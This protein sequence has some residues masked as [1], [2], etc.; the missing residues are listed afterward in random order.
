MRL[1]SSSNQ[2]GGVRHHERPLLATDSAFR[3]SDQTRHGSTTCPRGELGWPVVADRD[4]GTVSRISLSHD[5][6][7]AFRAPS[8]SRNIRAMRG[9]ELVV[10]A[11]VQEWIAAARQAS[12]CGRVLL[13]KVHQN[14]ESEGR[15]RRKN[16]DRGVTSGDSASSAPRRSRAALRYAREVTRG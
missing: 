4:A 8:S 5:W 10:H 11:M 16:A 9:V 15:S 6:A 12:P 3:T 2:I 1:R 13:C 14:E 7:C